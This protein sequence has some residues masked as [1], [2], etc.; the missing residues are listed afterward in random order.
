MIEF[1]TDIPSED[2]LKGGGGLPAPGVYH[3]QVESADEHESEGHIK[4]KCSIVSPGSESGKTFNHNVYFVG[5]DAEKTLIARKI[6]LGT[7]IRLGLTTQA[8]YDADKQAGR[9]HGIEW[10]GCVGNQFI[11]ELKAREYDR[12]DGSKGQS[13]NASIYAIDD[14]RA[15]KR[16]QAGAGFDLD[17]LSLVLPG[18]PVTAPLP[19]TTKPPANAPSQAKAPTQPP[20]QQQQQAKAPA[21][22]QSVYDDI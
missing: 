19:A 8:A 7:A 2:L 5:R 12:D 22:A 1:E 20:Q 4:L 13:V 16:L 15:T 11:A 21:Q 9:N 3:C 17:L 14:D 18:G 10:L 6:A